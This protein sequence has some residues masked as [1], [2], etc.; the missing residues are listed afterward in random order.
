MARKSFYMLLA[1]ILTGMTLMPFNHTFAVGSSS[2]ATITDSI[3]NVRSGPGLT[4]SVVARVQQGETFDV[5]DTQGDW[6][7]I[8]V[9]SVKKGWVANWVVSLSDSKTNHKDSTYTKKESKGIITTNGLRVRRGPG[10]GY[11]VEGVLSINTKVD[12]IGQSGNWIQIQTDSMQGYV[13]KEYITS[14]SASSEKYTKKIKSGTITGDLLNVR[15]SASSTAPVI[16]KLAKGTVVNVL[17]QDNN[18]TCILFKGQQAWVSSE[19][20]SVQ[21]NNSL[22]DHKNTI[23]V[24]ATSLRVRDSASSN[25]K[26]I[27]VV[28]QN[29]Q[30]SVLNEKNNWYQIE[31]ADGKKGWISS[32]YTEKND[33][34]TIQLT[35]TNSDSVPEGSQITILYDGTNIRSEA[36]THSSVTARANSGDTFDVVSI[37]NDW[38]EIKL[39][40]GTNGFI[41]GWLVSVKGSIPQ[42]N[43]Q[44]AEVYLRGK[45]IVIDAGHGG[46]DGGARGIRG[47]LE[48]NLTLR[49]AMQVSSKLKAAGAKVILTR[50]NDRYLAL[51]SRVTTS[52]LHGADAFISIHYD[53]TPDRS[54]NGITTY[55]NQYYQQSL[56]ETLHSSVIKATQLKNRGARYGDLHVIRENRQP[57]ILIELGYISNLSEEVMINSS[58]YQEAVANGFVN[59]LAA[60]FK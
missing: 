9:S 36:G 25:A 30:F 46:T 48:K 23:K 57:A 51:S 35:R 58:S 11:P 53:S 5:M 27:S 52:N 7:K 3:V 28:S 55:Y 17:N 56:A 22:N 21:S 39:K 4:H 33:S 40:N 60:Y 12:I 45:T 6:I 38:Y 26:Q 37:K 16:G 18:W 59:G 49:T 41:A 15:N 8:R 31:L 32:W 42:V 34:S 44:G 43:K 20:I 13:S 10:S 1:I 24:T 2:S 19:Y 47:T 14:M 50:N 54:A 29:Q